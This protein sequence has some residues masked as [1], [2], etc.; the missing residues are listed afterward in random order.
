MPILGRDD[1]RCGTRAAGCGDDGGG[2]E[3]NHAAPERS[4]APDLFAIC[5]SKSFHPAFPHDTGTL[6]RK[7]IISKHHVL[8]HRTG[9]ESGEIFSR[10]ALVTCASGFIGRLPVFQDRP[11]TAIYP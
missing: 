4:I 11:D 10:D 1:R 3:H 2:A 9:D 7:A 6:T 8:I 5:S